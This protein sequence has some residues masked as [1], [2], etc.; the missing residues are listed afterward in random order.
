MRHPQNSTALTPP[1]LPAEVEE[2]VEE[3]ED[4]AQP[5]DCQCYNVP[6]PPPPLHPQSRLL[7]F[8]HINK[9][10]CFSASLLI[11]HTVSNVHHSI[12]LNEFPM[13]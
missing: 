6:F 11:C 1:T 13:E 5:V 4:R 10:R 12:A 2:E 3:D 9:V 7:Q 8:P